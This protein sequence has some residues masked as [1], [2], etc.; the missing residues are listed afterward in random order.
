M[1]PTTQLGF[2]LGLRADHYAWILQE[3]PQLDWFE[4]V[5]E[6]FIGSGGKPRHILEQVRARYPVALHGVGLSIAS[7][8]RPQSSYLA[9]LRQLAHEI[10]PSCVSD[11]LCWTRHDGT[12]SHDLL[13]IAYTTG[14]L[15][16]V[17]A[18]VHEVQEALG[19]RLYLENASAYTAFA[20][21]DMDE[22]EFFA[23]L[24]Q[25][26]GCGMLLD[27]NNLYVNAMNF[28]I[29]AADYLSK[30]DP[31]AVGYMHLAGHS[32]LA[33]IRVDTHDAPVSDG[34]WLLYKQ[35]VC[36]FPAAATLLEWDGKVPTFVDLRAELG[37]AEAAHAAALSTLPPQTRTAKPPVQVQQQRSPQPD[38][39]ELTRRFWQMATGQLSIKPEDPRLDI[40]AARLP[41]PAVVGINV[42]AE[43]FFL[44]LEA[45]LASTFPTLVYILGKAD[46]KTLCKDYL[47]LYP[48]VDASIKYAGQTMPRYLSSI[49]RSDAGST[50]AVPQ[51]VLADVAA[52]EWASSDLIDCR[53]GAPGLPP[54][55]LTHISATAW[56]QTRFRFTHALSLI[57]MTYAVAPVVE[58]VASGEVP[59][60]PIAGSCYYL[61]YRQDEAVL[62]MLLSAP[63]VVCFEQLLNGYTFSDACQA[64]AACSTDDDEDTIITK[65]VGSLGKWLRAGLITGIEG[66]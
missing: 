7:L 36:R 10:Q 53:D 63:E 66:S 29:S 41:A 44:R 35:A 47:A 32:V 20:A 26:T 4:V 16:H 5:S 52:F 50:D 11:H 61:L 57:P 2:G 51:Q 34:V 60:R 62:Y 8:E 24:C 27:V 17:T 6:N 43:A 37:K 13:P 39:P 58:A 40:L 15:K 28:G 19:R 12:N 22:A 54:S 59:T 42:Y 64:A 21:A 45:A 23:E 55:D 25:A 49:V 14:V 9:G 3:Q 30:I 38:W 31:D 46:F 33:Q 18:R 56:E 48:A 1:T 65:M